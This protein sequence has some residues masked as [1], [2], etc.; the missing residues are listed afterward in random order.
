LFK[1]NRKQRKPY[2]VEKPIQNVVIHALTDSVQTYERESQA[3]NSKKV[4][5]GG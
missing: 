1:V 4:L 2:F 5:F 3:L